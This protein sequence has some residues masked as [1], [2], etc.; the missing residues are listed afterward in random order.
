MRY[1]EVSV[2]SSA[3]R[4][5]DRLLSIARLA[6]AVEMRSSKQSE[7][8]E[9]TVMWTNWFP[10]FCV[11]NGRSHFL[12][13]QVADWFSVDSSPAAAVESERE[14]RSKRARTK[15]AGARESQESIGVAWTVSDTLMWFEQKACDQP[16][17]LKTSS[18]I[19]HQLIDT[20][21]V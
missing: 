7:D 16:A 5:R 11:C 14:R 12:D 9:P 4:C 19:T 8:V 3:R 17:A 15:R 18:T 21:R 20:F 1:C 13:W 10:A 2:A 6:P